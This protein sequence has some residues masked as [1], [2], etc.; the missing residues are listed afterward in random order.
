MEK[1]AI[2]QQKIFFRK[3]EAVEL[4]VWLKSQLH[5]YIDAQLHR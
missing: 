2:T 4:T 3:I 1:G 5:T